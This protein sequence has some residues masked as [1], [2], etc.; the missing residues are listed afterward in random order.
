MSRPPSGEFQSETK[1]ER[2]ELISEGKSLAGNLLIADSVECWS[3]HC[4]LDTTL[5]DIVSDY[6]SFILKIKPN[7]TD[8]KND[9]DCKGFITSPLKTKKTELGAGYIAYRYPIKDNHNK[10]PAWKATLSYKQFQ[11]LNDDIDGDLSS[12]VQ[13]ISVFLSSRYLDAKAIPTDSI[14]THEYRLQ[15]KFVLIIKSGREINNYAPLMRDAINFLTGEIYKNRSESISIRVVEDSGRGANFFLETINQTINSNFYIEPL[16]SLVNR[17]ADNKA[18]TVFYIPDMEIP[19]AVGFSIIPGPQQFK[20]SHSGVFVRGSRVIRDTGNSIGNRMGHEM[21]HNMG[22][23]HETSCFDHENTSA[24][25][26]VCRHV[27]GRTVN[28]TKHSLTLAALRKNLMFTGDPGTHLNEQQKYMIKNS[29]IVNHKIIYEK[30]SVDTSKVEAEIYLKMDTDEI[31]SKEVPENKKEPASKKQEV[32]VNNVSFTINTTQNESF[33]NEIEIILS[34]TPEPYWLSYYLNF[35]AFLFE[36]NITGFT[37]RSRYNSDPL[38]KNHWFLKSLIVKIN[39]RIWFK[40]SDIGIEIGASLE[41][42]FK[43]ELKKPEVEEGKV[44][45]TSQVMQTL[46][47]PPFYKYP[48]AMN[49]NPNQSVKIMV[50]DWKKLGMENPAFTVQMWLYQENSNHDEVLTLLSVGDEKAGLHFF[51]HKNQYQWVIIDNRKYEWSKEI[52][53]I[54]FRRWTHLCITYDEK[55]KKGFIYRNGEPFFEAVKENGLP[56][57]LSGILSIGS[58]AKSNFFEGRLRNVALWK[59]FRTLQENLSDMFF[60][61]D[62]ETELAAYWPMNEGIGEICFDKTAKNN[63]GIISVDSSWYLPIQEQSH[64]LLFTSH[65]QPHYISLDH[66]KLIKLSSI[67][68]IMAW[69]RFTQPSQ[70]A[71]RGERIIFGKDILKLTIFNGKFGLSVLGRTRWRYISTPIPQ[72]Q[73]GYWFHLCGQYNQ[74]EK[75]FSIFYNGQ[76][77]YTKKKSDFQPR[78]SRDLCQGYIGGHPRS[79]SPYDVQIK[80]ILLLSNIIPESAIQTY[81]ETQALEKKY[82]K[83]CVAHF[84]LDEGAGNSIYDVSNISSSL[85]EKEME[86]ILFGDNIQ[87]SSAP[88]LSNLKARKDDNLKQTNYRPRVGHHYG[89][90]TYNPRSHYG[91]FSPLNTITPRPYMGYPPSTYGFT[92]SLLGGHV[93]QPPSPYPVRPR[94]PYIWHQPIPAHSTQTTSTL[95]AKRKRQHHTKESPHSTQSYRDQPDRPLKQQN[96]RRHSSKFGFEAPASQFQTFYTPYATHSV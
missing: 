92:T 69:I 13:N 2:L 79:H 34:N 40:K 10:Y 35:G 80:D 20:S 17:Q 30:I 21:G 90:P 65:N 87:W 22:L 71:I 64:C 3:L 72:D 4:I 42:E 83:D 62:S 31:D 50:A 88:K 12:R 54:D 9:T 25:I 78:V 74:K 67:I 60:I 16:K 84:P 28:Q 85:D 44:S 26:G 95:E 61:K 36:E 7:A 23:I 29:P 70:L 33:S 27:I 75:I 41:S 59:K 58:D 6:D 5:Y 56:N 52:P 96:V 14:Q 81:I 48:I 46:S 45:T 39:N 91:S 66:Q 63:H 53:G 93:I 82:E 37:F 47:V 86:G 43:N 1:V 18:M 94:Y 77:R 32:A 51:L 68:V 89:S 49:F 15:V 55:Q 57:N 76:L 24:D 19:D 8:H 11:L 38:Q 73:A